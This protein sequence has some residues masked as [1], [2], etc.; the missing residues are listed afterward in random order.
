MAQSVRDKIRAATLGKPVQFKSKVFDYEG[1]DVEFRQPNL[2]DRQLLINKA[3]K[4]DGEL[5]FV[6][7]LVWS[8]IANTYVPETSEKVFDDADYDVM[9]KQNSG[10]FVDQFGTEIASLMN[11]EEGSAK[12]S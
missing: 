3:R 10:S 11:V 5:D 4:A 7:F 9:I 1:I 6:E 2:K 12:N 8:V